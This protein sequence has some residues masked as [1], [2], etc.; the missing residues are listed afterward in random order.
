MW[1][2][3]PVSKLSDINCSMIDPKNAEGTLD[4][5]HNEHKCNPAD[6]IRITR[7]DD[8]KA[9]LLCGQIIATGSAR[10]LDFREKNFD[11]PIIVIIKEGNFALLTGILSSF[12]TIIITRLIGTFKKK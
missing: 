5:Q 11:R 7:G 2:R 4:I 8:M 9:S 3:S 12:L 6:R 10:T 1:I